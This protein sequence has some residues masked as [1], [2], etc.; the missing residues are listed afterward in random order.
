MRDVMFYLEAQNKVEESSMK[1]DIQKGEVVMIGTPSNTPPG[2]NNPG[3]S[4]GGKSSHNR[5]KRSGR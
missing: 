4:S 1:E 5:R 3:S 2:P